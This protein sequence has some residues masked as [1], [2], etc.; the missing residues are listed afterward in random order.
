MVRCNRRAWLAAVAAACRD[1]PVEAASLMRATSLRPA[2]NACT[3]QRLHSHTMKKD[4]SAYGDILG[5][6]AESRLVAPARA[7]LNSSP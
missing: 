5:S 6:S 1:M 7:A 3:A 2:R 4:M